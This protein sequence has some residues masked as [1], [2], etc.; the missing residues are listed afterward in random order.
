MTES[1]RVL[2]ADDHP[3]VRAGLRATLSTASDVRLVGEATDG[4]ATQRMCR[5]LQPD[6]L[7]LDLN[8]PGPPA[9][10]TIEYL[11]MH[12]PDAR[13]LVLTIDDDN[14]SVQR[15][16]GAGAV[17]YVLKDEAIDVV[18]NA[19]RAAAQ[20]GMW[21]SPPIIEKLARG[22]SGPPP[23]RVLATLT[24]RE[25]QILGMIAQGWDNARIASE[26][27]LSEQTVR[28]HASRIYAKLGVCSRGEAIVWARERGMDGT[29][30]V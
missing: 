27:N 17:G 29:A 23:Q 25:R 26:C 6:V 30:S 20:G 19:I 1:I 28:N 3:L 7:L 8:M 5:E 24:E 15:M 10:E 13:V 11:R 4:Y 2:L 9:T 12:C 14:A 18:V 16:L 21:F 22:Q